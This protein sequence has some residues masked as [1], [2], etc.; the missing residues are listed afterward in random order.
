MQEAQVE[1]FDLAA[2]KRIVVPQRGKWQA[3]ADQEWFQDRET[4]CETLLSRFLSPEA[5]AESTADD[6]AVRAYRAAD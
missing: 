3:Y 6:A 4:R 2:L 5:R 1:D